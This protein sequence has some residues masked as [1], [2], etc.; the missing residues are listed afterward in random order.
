MWLTLGTF[1]AG[2]GGKI[3]LGLVVVAALGGM[4]WKLVADIETIGAQKETI[5][6]LEQTNKENLVELDKIKADAA[7]A[8]AA[9]SATLEQERQRATERTSV[10]RIIVN[11]SP[12]DDGAVAPVL[13]NTFDGLYGQPGP[14]GLDQGS[15]AGNPGRA[16]VV[17]A[18]ATK[19]N[20]AAKPKGGRT[21]A[22]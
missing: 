11:A 22:P 18:G 21:A 14:S 16:A 4:L 8:Q 10:Q 19:A 15:K 2:I 1:L 12:K 9:L 7:A 17:P 6:T 3:L 20:G 13:S 5:A